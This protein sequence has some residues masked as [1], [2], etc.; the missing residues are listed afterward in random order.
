M[1]R[2]PAVVAVALA[3][4]CGRSPSACL[5]E[6]V[7]SGPADVATGLWKELVAAGLYPDSFVP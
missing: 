2:S 6:V 1:S 4:V 7:A 3:S 5:E